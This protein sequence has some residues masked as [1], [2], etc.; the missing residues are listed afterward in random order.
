[1]QMTTYISL[2]DGVDLGLDKND[3]LVV[4]TTKHGVVTNHINLGPCTEQRVKEIHEY[5]DRIA[6]LATRYTP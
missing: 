1:M 2:G 3:N 5:L 4:L 6:A